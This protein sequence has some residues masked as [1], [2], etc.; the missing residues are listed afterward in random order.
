MALT[1]LPRFSRL[2]R[3][4]LTTANAQRL[5]SFYVEAFGACRLSDERFC[6]EA[7]HHVMGIES[8]ARCITLCLG[9]STIDLVEFDVS[10]APYPAHTTACDSHFQHLAIVVSD[11]M[12]AWFQLSRTG[13]WSPITDGLPLRLPDSSG[14]VTA[15]KFRDP[16][17]HPLELLSFPPERTPEKWQVRKSARACLG[18]D[19]SAVAVRDTHTSIAFYTA[20][21]L[22][23]SS[24][25]HNAGPEQDRLD[26]LAGAIV[27]V[28]ALAPAG[29]VPHLELLRYREKAKQPLSLRGNDIATTRLIFESDEISAA[30]A[31]IDPDGH[32]L[33][34]VPSPQPSRPE[35]R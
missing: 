12:E 10:G 26:G 6:G 2:A 34:V 9:S 28:T 32:H 4:S 30:C 13:G 35:W 21:G 16:E 1:P 25:S 17:G 8:D 23:L 33:I 29:A 3:F 18:I 15:F 11:M 5:A 27:D 20:H 22:C 19:H 14:G 31:I 24:R 7:F